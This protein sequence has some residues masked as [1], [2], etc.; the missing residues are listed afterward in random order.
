MVSFTL[1][2]FSSLLYYCNSFTFLR[3]S[4]GDQNVKLSEDS[5]CRKDFVTNVAASV[6]STFLLPVQSATARGR[7]TLEYSLERYYPRIEAGGAFYANDLKKAIER[8][9]WQAIKAATSEP[10]KRSKEDKSKVDGGIAERAAQAGGFSNARVITACDLWAASFSDNSIST[11]TKRMKE[12]TDILKEVV[13]GMN[14]AA[15]VALGE[16][17]VGGGFFGFGSKVPSQL[18][19]AQQVRELY[20]KGGNA[21][22]QFIFISNDELPVQLQK[23]PYL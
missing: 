14:S 10:P 20:I 18:E 4:F 19:L 6:S 21:W 2:V 12:Q 9:D 15:L 5:I 7:A 16:V 8:N 17:K 22:N 1:F 3:T 23:L 11:K 13:V